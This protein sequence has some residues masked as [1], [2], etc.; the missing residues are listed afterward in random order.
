MTDALKETVRSWC[1]DQEIPLFGV[2]DVRRWEQPPFQPWMP[3]AFYPRSIFPEAESAIVIGLPVSLPAL[4]TSP[5]I[6]YRELYITVNT[7]LDT[8]TYRLSEFLT[9]RGYPSVFIPR[10][11]YGSIEVLLNVP[12][13]F[14]SHRHAAYFAG[15]GNFGVNNMILTPEFGPRVRFGTV[16]TSARLPPDPIREDPLCIRCMRCVEMCPSSALKKEDYPDAITDKHACASWSAE[17]NRRFITPCGI[18]IK[19][20]PVGEDRKKFGREDSSVYTD[21]NRNPGLHQAWEHVQRYGGR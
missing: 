16:L 14:F 15:L 19:V 5:S 13:A 17:L 1:R 21:R 20:C 4:E 18:C 7:L 9:A 10:D 11:G 12:V 8:S 6:H 3:E 2:A